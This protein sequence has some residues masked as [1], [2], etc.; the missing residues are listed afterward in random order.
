MIEN[1]KTSR[2]QM[3]KIWYLYDY[4]GGDSS[5]TPDAEKEGIVEV[6][7]CTDDNLNNE[8]V[9]PDIIQTIKID[10]LS[11]LQNGIIDSGIRTP[12]W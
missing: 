7:W 4:L 12:N 6:G 3:V 1:L 2:Y 11:K 10:G 5:L 8:T 9:F